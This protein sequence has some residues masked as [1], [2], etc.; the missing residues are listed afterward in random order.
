MKL[1]NETA[2]SLGVESTASL[3]TATLGKIAT[4]PVATENS[5]NKI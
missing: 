2:G 3:S 1:A 5:I 4:V